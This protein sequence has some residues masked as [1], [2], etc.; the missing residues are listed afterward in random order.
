MPTYAARLPAL[1]ALNQQQSF[2]FMSMFPGIQLKCLLQSERSSTNYLSSTI[3]MQT[4]TGALHP[5]NGSEDD[6]R[7]LE[8]EEFSILPD[9]ILHLTRPF[10]LR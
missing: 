7:H 10:R 3:Y 4:D 9:G 6:T 5:T 1:P 8:V 2:E